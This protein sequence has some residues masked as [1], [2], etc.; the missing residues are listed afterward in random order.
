MIFQANNKTTDYW[1]SKLSDE[2][3]IS[4]FPW[5][6]TSTRENPT[7][8]QYTHT[9]DVNTTQLVLA[10][11]RGNQYALFI[12]LL[13]ALQVVLS[14]YTGSSDLLVGIPPLKNESEQSSISASRLLPLR[15]DL[16][17][18][19]SYKQILESVKRTVSD[20][21]HHQ[22]L[23]FAEFLHYP[24]TGSF[25]GFKTIV[26][27][28]N[29]HAGVE[30]VALHTDLHF[31]FREDKGTI[32]VTV[33]FNSG[34]HTQDRIMQFIGNICCVLEQISMHPDEPVSGAELLTLTKQQEL[35]DSFCH[36]GGS[37]INAATVVK[38]FETMAIQYPASP[39][40]IDGLHT[41]SYASLNRRANQLAH[42]LMS[43][44]LSPAKPVGVL[45]PH[46]IEQAVALIGILKANAA[47]VPLDAENP[48]ERIRAIVEDAGIEIMISSK[49]YIRL[50]NRMQWECTGLRSFLCMDSLN[51]Y[52]EC[53][54]ETNS[55]MDT[56]LWEFFGDTSVDEITGGGWVNSYTGVSLS[57]E[58]ME[59]YGENVLHKLQPY[60]SA[61]QR[62]LE[63]GCAS[64]ITMFRVAPLVGEYYGTDLSGTILVKNQ[65]RIEQMGFSNIQLRKL[66][67]H[68]ID[69]IAG[70]FDVVIMNSVVQ[71]F[72]GHNYFRQVLKKAIGKI[73]AHGIIFI[74]DIMDQDLKHQYLQSIEE[75]ARSNQSADYSTKT[76]WNE[77]LFLCR[78][79][80]QDL[81]DEFSEIENIEFS[82]KLGHIKNEL[83]E[84]R[85]D[86]VLVI[87]KQQK[88]K[89]K[90]AK[91][92]KHKF[93]FDMRAMEPYA[94]AA[95]P[96]TESNLEQIAYIIYTSGTT[97][98]PKGVMVSHRGLANL[99]EWHNRRFRVGPDS[100]ATRYAGFGFDASVWELVPYLLEG[101]SVYYIDN[102]IKLD[103]KRLNHFFEE[104]SIT[105]S[106]LPT[107]I[108]EQFMDVENRS[109]RYLLTGGDTLRIVKPTPYE[110]V[111]NYGPTENTVVTTS[112]MLNSN[113][114]IITIGRPIDNVN[115]YILDAYKHLQPIG[116]PGEIYIAGDSL[117]VGYLHQAALT[118]EKFVSNPFR[119]GTRMFKSGDMGRWLSN[120]DI[121]FL[122]RA[123]C[124]VKIRGFRLELAEIEYN[125]LQLPYIKDA[126]VIDRQEA[127]G[128]RYLCAY[129][130]PAHQPI[131][132]EDL[133]RDL[134]KV[135]PEY[136]IPSYFVPLTSIPLNSS[137]KVNRK[138]LPEPEEKLL[139][140]LHNYIA[141]RN[142]KEKEICQIWQSVLGVGKVG[143]RDHF[144]EI[145]GNSLKA[146]RVVSK[147]SEQFDVSINQLFQYNTIE[148]L[149]PQIHFL[150]QT[151]EQKIEK[152]KRYLLLTREGGPLVEE[153]SH[154]SESYK[155]NLQLQKY[156]SIAPQG[157]QVE[158]TKHVLLTGASGYLGIHLLI[159]MLQL[160]PTDHLYLLKRGEDQRKAEAELIRKLIFYY[161]KEMYELYQYRIHVVCGD[162]TLPY[163]G[164][165]EAEY[166]QLAAQMDSIVH[167]AA[168]VKHYGSYEEFNKVN[169]QGTE[170]IISFAFSTRWK[171]LHFISTM[172]V[173]SGKIE[174]TPCFL[175]TEDDCDVEQQIHN[176]YTQTKL[177][178]ELRVLQAREA[179]L[180]A[181]IFR[182]G[183][184]VCHSTTGQFQEN[185]EENGF[186]KMLKSFIKLR[187]M[188]EYS[189]HPVDFTF[190][191]EA[192][193]AIVKLMADDDCRQAI[194]HVYN[195]KFVNLLQ[196]SQMLNCC[197]FNIDV[198]PPDEFLDWMYNNRNSIDYEELV[199][200][201]MLHSRILDTDET[202]FVTASDRTTLILQQ[203]GFEWPDV[204]VEHIKKM[205]DYCLK[206]S[207]L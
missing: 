131:E 176:H 116:A 126:V 85:F 205:T 23:P 145:G 118:A 177:E 142:E 162:I 136:M 63:I 155:K 41:L 24:L 156:E 70:P 132:P 140:K 7:L 141:P 143:I 22:N 39:A 73:S 50:L 76:E 99:C 91:Y 56:K 53:E 121:E 168:N 10:Q 59:E 88:P 95:N 35:L 69:T 38:S 151:L 71:C 166:N 127:G 51:I 75:Y 79:F 133:L 123:D 90:I 29:I 46:S 137:G 153:R 190:V 67:A 194:Y 146:V 101:A 14:K 20:V 3:Q 25:D 11:S 40:V 49:Q 55:L 173:A 207:Y 2:L 16:N 187:S 203:L 32:R 106:F 117:A 112:G 174:E 175:F 5:E 6:S 12:M 179:G 58:E 130:V 196:L 113:L 188:P 89:D 30:G 78:S 144:F 83:T 103:M 54:Q 48:E 105:I 171:R 21:Y 64:G 107:Q 129:Y 125:L 52:E 72:H 1:S 114:E 164:M 170:H 119:P 108:C 81:Q 42:F 43:N 198:L 204:E 80:L 186:Y 154:K 109:L 4:Q 74:G 124:Q 93:Q 77:E 98:S 68:E 150:E 148:M 33:Y 189:P 165:D 17:I 152:A 100:R 62:V 161:S 157:R 185:I 13:S 195:P 44:N 206:I 26:S 110:L 31:A 9:V 120:G 65:S 138:Q 60:L 181:S 102:Q 158:G 15:V 37:G 47:F 61:N 183:N 135:L 199:E 45:L 149:A 192:S 167:A 191:N 169:V 201:I 57:R 202:F 193:R 160:S 139:K 163:F 134:T 19:E 8:Q 66:P 182:V 180:A 197:G 36:T 178:A 18:E 97:G 92:A 200:N 184:L 34:Y 28:E 122:G 94:E 172:G 111:N 147:M 104:N 27:L 84:Y 86:A 115:V 128:D 82:E 96:V 87:N 159:E